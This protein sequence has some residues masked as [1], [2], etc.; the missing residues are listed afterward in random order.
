MIDNDF[1]AELS[2][3]QKSA[4]VI[5][6]GI[7][8]G[9]LSLFVGS[10]AS[11]MLAFSMLMLMAFA[12]IVLIQQNWVIP[13]L[14]VLVSIILSYLVIVVF[15]Y[16]VVERQRSYVKNLF[17]L[18]LEPHLVDQMMQSEKLPE[19]GGEERI[20]TAWFADLADFTTI[21]EGLS[22]TEL[23]SLM[24]LYF[25]TVTDIIEAHGG[26]VVQYVGDEVYAVFGA[27]ADDP[28]AAGHAVAAAF[29]VQN[30][31]QQLNRDDAF[32]G[33]KVTARVGINRGNAIVGNVGSSNRFNFAIMGDTVNLGS[34]LEGANKVM[35]TQIL[36][37]ESVAE[38][39]PS[40]IAVREVATL[41][42]KG[43]EEPCRV[44]EPFYI[45]AERFQSRSYQDKAKQQADSRSV[46][47]SLPAE[48]R[49]MSEDFASAQ[50]LMK[51][52]Q[53]QAAIDILTVYTNDPVAEKIIERARE[54]MNSAEDWQGVVSLKT[55]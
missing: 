14:P 15:K 19:L 41:Q 23:I 6:A 21:S 27:L 12:G 13:A 17:G 47:Q 48:V 7:I 42:V 4:L 51:E 1:L 9:M 31:L 44:F 45:Q 40:S 28:D 20:V 16:V 43:K 25:K 11:A 37:S 49:R 36:I 22:P 3:L 32:G 34:R 53:F 33:K 26:F 5:G 38:N 24:N 55:K 2:S 35:N 10:I 54:L 29:Q 46:Q 18:Y 8:T 52:R 39:L 30:K 50:R